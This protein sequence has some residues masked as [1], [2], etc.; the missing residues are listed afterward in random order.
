MNPIAIGILALSLSA[1][2][3]IASLARGA[4]GQRPS[5]RRVIGT[6]AIF[7]VVEMLTPLIGWALG[8]ATSQYVQIFD[9]WIAFGLLS[10]VGAHMLFQ[11]LSA[12]AESQ[13]RPITFWAVVATAVGTSIDAMAIG[14]SLAFLDVNI[15]IIAGAIGMATMVMSMVGLAAGGFLGRKFGRIIEAFGGLALIALGTSILLHHLSGV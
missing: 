4:R 7:G 3:F 15:L 8:V 9:H 12:D 11:A 1:D 5:L 14:V 10:A 13:P 6:G 2:A